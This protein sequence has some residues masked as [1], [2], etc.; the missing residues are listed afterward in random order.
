MEILFLRI[1]MEVTLDWFRG[2]TPGGN[3][4]SAVSPVVIGGNLVIE[5]TYPSGFT[6]NTKDA[7]TFI[8]N[9]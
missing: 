7:T 1:P 5:T 8:F 2:G 4:G 3:V 6:I 9:C